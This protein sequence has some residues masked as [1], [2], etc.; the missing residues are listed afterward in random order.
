MKLQLEQ[1]DYQPR[2][3]Q[4]ASQR[5]QIYFVARDLESLSAGVL[6]SGEPCDRFAPKFSSNTAYF[7]LTADKT[8]GVTH[9]KKGLGKLKYNEAG[10]EYGVPLV[11]ILDKPM[12]D[13]R[14]DK[15]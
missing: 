8:I 5:E 13:W 15:K 11:D 7:P 12:K 10:F 1:M 2:Q 3:T 9:H 14:I 6:Y 4:E